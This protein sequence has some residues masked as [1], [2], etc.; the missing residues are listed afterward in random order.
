MDMSAACQCS[1][2]AT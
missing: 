1:F 2:T